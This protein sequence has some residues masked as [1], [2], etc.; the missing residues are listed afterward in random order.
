LEDLRDRRDRGRIDEG[1]YADLATDLDRE[2]IETL[3]QLRILLQSADEDIS[4][5]VA[6]AISGN[7]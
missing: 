6:D 5:I 4:D 1:R 2:R 7:S 3:I